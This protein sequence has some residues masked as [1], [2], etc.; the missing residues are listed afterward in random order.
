MLQNNTENKQLIFC[1]IFRKNLEIH[2]VMW[3]YICRQGDRLPSKTMKGGVTMSR[4][5]YESKGSTF[6]HR[7]KNGKYVIYGID[8]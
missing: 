1:I 4:G 5:Y 6:G 3:Y 7:M 2:F 8:V